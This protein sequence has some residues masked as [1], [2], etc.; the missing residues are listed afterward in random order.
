MQKCKEKCAMY[1]WTKNET[2]EMFNHQ[3]TT[4]IYGRYL[5]TGIKKCLPLQI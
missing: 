1:N 2:P 3:I 4:E 5:L